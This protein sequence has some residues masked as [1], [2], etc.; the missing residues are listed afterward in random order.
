M[1]KRARLLYERGLISLDRDRHF[2]ISYVQFIEKYL[3][4]PALVRAKFENRLKHCDKLETIDIMLEN[5]L[6]EEEQ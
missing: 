3:K 6:F 2:W 5:A 1:L 4:D